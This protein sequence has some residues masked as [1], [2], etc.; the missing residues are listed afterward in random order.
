MINYRTGNAIILNWLQCIEGVGY[1]YSGI[2]NGPDNIS[3]PV[4]GKMCPGPRLEEKPGIQSG[5]IGRRT[6]C[7]TDAVYDTHDVLSGS[8]S[9]G[10]QASGE[11]YECSE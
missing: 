10:M 4:T 2:H 5:W 1:I 8:A 7:A 3:G 6:G 9:M 11:D